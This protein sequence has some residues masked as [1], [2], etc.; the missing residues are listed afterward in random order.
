MLHNTLVDSMNKFVG[1]GQLPK[2]EAALW[3]PK[4]S[5]NKNHLVFRPVDWYELKKCKTEAYSW[6]KAGTLHFLDL[7]KK[8][9]VLEVKGTG[10]EVGG[11]YDKAS[12]TSEKDRGEMGGHDKAAPASQTDWQPKYCTTC[13]KWGHVAEYCPDVFLEEDQPLYCDICNKEGHW[14]EECWILHPQLKAAY[15]REQ[16]EKAKKSTCHNC[17]RTGHFRRF[18]HLL[19][20]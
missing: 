11:S 14:E 16:K 15:L 2:H 5:D 20:K 12:A 18:C 10:H 19:H 17:G 1:I 4:N 9:G 13:Q 3:E 7:E 8:N 6:M